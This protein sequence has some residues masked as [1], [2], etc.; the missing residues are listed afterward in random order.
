MKVVIIS[1]L[2][3]QYA[4]AFPSQT[5]KFPFLSEYLHPNGQLI[6]AATKYSQLIFVLIDKELSLFIATNGSIGLGSFKKSE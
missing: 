3:R 4:A 1:L 6:P 2:S 5:E